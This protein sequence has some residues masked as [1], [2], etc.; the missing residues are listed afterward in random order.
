MRLL[1]SSL[2]I[3][4]VSACTNAEI[5]D[6]SADRLSYAYC[7]GAYAGEGDFENSEGGALRRRAI[8]ESTPGALLEA[9]NPRVM[10]DFALSEL[11][12]ISEAQPDSVRQELEIEFQRARVWFANLSYPFSEKVLEEFRIRGVKCE[13]AMSRLVEAG[14]IHPNE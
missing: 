3:G 5:N 1:G 12:E 6:L 11:A 13:A 10:I 2:F 7:I 9:L 4:F 14:E 8:I